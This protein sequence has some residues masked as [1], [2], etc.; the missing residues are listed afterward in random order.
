MEQVKFNSF[1]QVFDTYRFLLEDEQQCISNQT[2]LS[3]LSYLIDANAMATIISFYNA[4][5]DM[6]T[7]GGFWKSN[8]FTIRM[9]SVVTAEIV[10]FLEQSNVFNRK[11]FEEPNS[12][13]EIE[14]LRNKIHQ[15]R[16]KD[17]SK[18]IKTIDSQMG[19][20][21]DKCA[22]RLDV[23]LEYISD[24]SGTTF[25]ET[26]I[27]QF[28]LQEA[29]VQATVNLMQRIIRTVAD[30]PFL[31]QSDFVLKRNTE[32]RKH[33]WEVY[34]YTD[35]VKNAQLQDVRLIDRILMAM[36]DLSCIYEFFTYMLVV[37]DYLMD[38]PYMIYFLN[39]SIA[40]FLDETFDNINQYIKYSKSTGD[41]AALE[42]IM[43]NV[44]Q[45]FIKYCATLRNNLHYREQVSLHL[46]TNRELYQLLVQELNIVKEMLFRVQEILNI[47]PCKARLY[48][49]RF[50]RW[51][52]MPNTRKV[53]IGK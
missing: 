50:L 52:Q 16:R 26:N 28:H 1:N 35:I 45:S 44:D 36:D 9:Y 48:Y 46:G 20:S 12:L 43:R 25:L 7:N 24:S 49:Y 10:K 33:R 4:N 53:R 41:K 3:N 15:F 18:Y 37:D 34:C 13:K 6:G 11:E 8:L 22:P 27:Y 29:K 42:S 17:F 31:P 39:K 2:V 51:V 5:F 38:A 30:Q 21:R 19:R 14:S 23:C 40:I 47:K 32:R